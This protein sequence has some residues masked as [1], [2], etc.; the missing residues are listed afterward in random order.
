MSIFEEEEELQAMRPRQ[1][2]YGLPIEELT[3]RKAL[4]YD[5]ML[6][7]RI[8]KPFNSFLVKNGLQNRMYQQ[9]ARPP[10]I[11]T[12]A[13]S[14][15]TMWTVKNEDLLHESLQ[16][17][18]AQETQK[19]GA[20]DN[21]D[22]HVYNLENIFKQNGRNNNLFTPKTSEQ[23]DAN[24]RMLV[25]NIAAGRTYDCS[26]D[27]IMSAIMNG[28]FDEYL[29]EQNKEQMMQICGPAAEAEAAAAAAEATA[30]AA[31]EEQKGFSFK[32]LFGLGGRK[33]KRSKK[34]NIKRSKKR[35][36]RRSK[37]RYNRRSIKCS[38]SNKKYRGGYKGMFNVPPPSYLGSIQGKYMNLDGKQLM[39]NPTNGIA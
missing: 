4:Y 5:F 6:Y 35:N 3:I 29:S 9:V 24:I 38:K 21:I 17:F 11:A 31:A 20:L 19:T 7:R 32:S 27:A 36:N 18:L 39:T 15:T 28:R 33:M 22:T 12:M 26:T 16:Q 8:L 23:I 25:S 14:G 30:E 37:K 2:M 10:V 1:T 34:R 13:S